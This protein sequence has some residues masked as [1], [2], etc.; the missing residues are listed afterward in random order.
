MPT[1]DHACGT[2]SVIVIGK[3]KE[4]IYEVAGNMYFDLLLNAQLFVSFQPQIEQGDS[5]QSSFPVNQNARGVAQRHRLS[6]RFG[7]ARLIWCH[8]TEV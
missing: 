7:A 4:E 8:H 5:A 3:R 6:V 2:Q 1:Y